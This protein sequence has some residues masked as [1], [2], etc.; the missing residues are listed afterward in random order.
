MRPNNIPIV[1][2]DAGHGLTTSGKQTPD[3]IKEWTLNDKVRDKVVRYLMDYWVEFIFPDNN[4]GNTDESLAKRLAAYINSGAKAMVSIHHNAFLGT[5]GSANGT[6]TYTDK[7][8]TV[9]DRRL[10]EC[11][12]KRLVQYTG[13]K[14]R[15]IKAEA[16]YVINQDK[17]PAVLTEGGFMDNREDYA[18]I[19]SEAGQNAYARAVAEGLIEFL[20]LQ[21]RTD[22]MS[23]TT[24]GSAQAPANG[25][26]KDLGKVNITYQ[27][28]TDRWWPLVINQNDWAG[29][30]DNTPIRYLAVKVSKGK[31]RGRVY[32]EASGWL[33]YL[34]F[35]DSY[36]LNDLNYGVLGD[37]SPIQAVEL[38]YYTPDGYEYQVVNYRVS[39]SESKEYYAVQVDNKK[40]EDMDGYAGKIGTFVDK[41]QAWIE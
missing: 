27:A 2:L 41:F 19:T 33:P 38:Y 23:P 1:A 8:P 11:I 10:A 20:G 28:F 35:S 31:I 9:A 32:T 6:E 12:H 5:W 34:T 14:D 36:N 25:N 22:S 13:L 4:E 7:N 26:K 21:K 24:N 16:W 37:G 15:G 17:I 18:V 30:G 40:N 39:S 3:G 29:K